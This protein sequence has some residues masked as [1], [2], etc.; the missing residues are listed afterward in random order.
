LFQKPYP[1]LDWIQV[2][3]SSHCNADCI[4]CPHAA[5]KKNWQHR[6]L[7][8]NVFQ[9]LIPAFANTRLI[10]LQGWGE[11][12]LHPK[13]FGM[14]KS[15]KKAG[16]MVGTTT[17]ATVLTEN[18]IEA[19]VGQGLDVIGF[20][21][22]G[23]DAKNDIIRK[24]TSLKKTLDCI[25]HF[26]K[27]RAKFK[28]NTP[29]IHIAY[30]LTRSG[31][32]DLEKIP[33]FIADTGVDQTVIS[34]LSLAVNR[35][36]ETESILAVGDGEIQELHSRLSE[37]RK[38]ACGKRLEIHFHIVSPAMENFCCSENVDRAVVI[39]SDG[40]ISPCVFAQIPMTGENYYY[41]NGQ[42]RIHRNL[43]YGNIQT[44]SLNKIW[45]QQGYQQF[46]RSHRKGFVP[47][48]CSSC[49]KAFI[50]NF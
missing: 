22:A 29:K 48:T 25:K 40:S 6:H 19:L 24:G 33:A 39:G 2:E 34:S 12:F 36:M 49:Y 21:L 38:E 15:A 42:K 23:I 47:G 37:I 14:L 20:S 50:T 31:L 41:F 27:A 35:D 17:N 18:R 8:G 45:H 1:A 11:P 30:L 10:Y 28:T 32:N 4:Y 46:L 26:Q 7:P 44:A 16:C 13:F 3:I 43:S 5:Y 9:K